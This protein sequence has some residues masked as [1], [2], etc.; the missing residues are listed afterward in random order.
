MTS[1][2]FYRP[3]V[4]GLTRKEKDFINLSGDG[5]LNY[6]INGKELLTRNVAERGFTGT[7]EN[8]RA[9]QVTY[10]F[11]FTV[12]P[13]KFATVA[14]AGKFFKEKGAYGAAGFSFRLL[15]EFLCRYYN[16]GEYFIDTYIRDV[17]HTRPVYEDFASLNDR[18]R[19]AVRKEEADRFSSVPTKKDGTPDMR[20]S[21][22]RAF[23]N[24]KVWRDPVVKMECAR[25]ARAIKKDIV[26]CLSTGKIPLSKQVVARRTADERRKYAG[27]NIHQFFYAS[28]RLIESLNMFVEMGERSN[29]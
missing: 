4:A 24:F 21:V 16:S 8:A 11:P 10:S 13:N 6:F 14:S 18:I 22:S 27:M 25:V 3:R 26:V 20:F 23:M 2:N 15:Y 28:G 9:F 5:G 1:S 29:G 17:F 7:K 12:R 19:E